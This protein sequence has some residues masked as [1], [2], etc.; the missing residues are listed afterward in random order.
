MFLSKSRLTLFAR[1]LAYGGIGAIAGLVVGFVV[2]LIAATVLWALQGGGSTGL[3]FRAF[4]PGFAVFGFMFGS[5]V[6]AVFGAL[7]GM[8]EE[9]CGDEMS[10]EDFAMALAEAEAETEP[11]VIVQA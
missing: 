6:F 4:F 11:T 9:C 2:A 10:D 8:R 3:T 7:V 1:A 5:I